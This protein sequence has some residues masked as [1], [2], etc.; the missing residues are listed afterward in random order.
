[1]HAYADGARP[2]R[3]AAPTRSGSRSTTVVGARDQRGHRAPARARARRR[4]DR[5]RRHALQP[6]RVPGAQPRRAWRRRSSP[7][8]RSA[9]RSSTRRASRGSS[10]A[11]RH[12]AAR[13]LRRRPG[14]AAIVVAVLASPALRNVIE[15]LDARDRQ[16]ASGSRRPAGACD[17]RSVFDLRYHVAS[18]AA[19]FVALVIGIFVGV[20]LSGQGLR[21]RRRAREPP[22]QIDELQ[23]RARRRRRPRSSAASAA[24][25]RSTTSPTTAYPSLVRRTA[26]REAGRGPLRRL[27]RPGRRRRRSGG[28]CA[29]RAARVVRMRA[30]RRA[31]RPGRRST[32]RS[33]ADPESRDLRRPGA[34][35]SE[36]GDALARRARRRRPDA[37]LGCA[38]ADPRRG[39]QGSPRRRS[40]PSS[41]P[42]RP[43]RSRARRRT[44]SPG[45]TRAR[46]ARR[47]RRRRRAARRRSRAPCPPSA[48]R[49]LS[50]VDSV[51]DRR[52]AARARA[53][54]S[55]AREPGSYGVGTRRSR[56]RAARPAAL[57]RRRVSERL[58]VLVA[59]R[60]EEAR[61]GATVDGAARRFPGR[62][63]SS[64][65]TT[66]RATRRPTRAEAAGAR[67]DPAPAPR[68]R[69]RR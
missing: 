61:I 6:R 12:L 25:T 18:L 49:G 2:G 42:A 48:R 33:A 64:S 5:R 3:R 57:S 36:L 63:R 30:A 35:A 55:P 26:R 43:S 7:G 31:A 44:S 53:A 37:A 17:T 9:S 45:S 50:T 24:A 32:R 23:R 13:R 10:A 21:Q 69:G 47:A 19:V 1:M 51:D 60:D 38:R 27:G 54:S 67:V 16:R 56:R 65:P 58:T 40:T 11:G 62:G 29:T 8:S 59:A 52:R 34:A 66:A 22:G 68:A 4:A 14:I 41:S 39:A 15:S 20:G 46:P 28:R